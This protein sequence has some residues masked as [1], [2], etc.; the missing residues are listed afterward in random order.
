MYIEKNSGPKT[1]PRGTPRS[2]AS[3]RVL[4]IG[5]NIY[6]QTVK[7]MIFDKQIPT[8]QVCTIK[9]NRGSTVSLVGITN[10][11]GAALK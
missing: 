9:G 8:L 11:T 7:L 1:E 5:L 6:M 4:Y 10:T 2:A 3:I